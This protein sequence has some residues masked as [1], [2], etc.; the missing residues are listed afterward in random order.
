MLRFLFSLAFVL[1]CV[2]EIVENINK[3][4]ERKWQA[5]LH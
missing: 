5:Y 1:H 4:P 2:K 3:K